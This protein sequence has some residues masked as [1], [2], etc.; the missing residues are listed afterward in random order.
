MTS[1]YYTNRLG[2]GTPRLSLAAIAAAACFTAGCGYIGG[3]LPPFANIPSPVAN[4]NAVQRGDKLIVQFPVPTLTTEGQ[5]L[6]PPVTPELRIGDHPPA[7]PA[8]TVKDGFARYEIPSTGWIGKDA[9]ITARVVGSN[10]KDSGWSAPITVSVVA[11]P[12]VPHDIRAESTAGGVRLTWQSSG[13]HFHILRRSGKETAYSLAAADVTQHEWLDSTAEFG[14]PYSYL[15]QTFVPLP[16]GKEAQSDLPEATSLTP[17]APPPGVP[18][19]LRA[20]PASVSIE[21]SWDSPQGATP[22][23][24]RLYR[25][26]AGGDFVKIADVSGVPTYSDHTVEAG[27]V[28]RY[29]V[30][31]VDA[32]G[33]EGPRCAPVEASLQ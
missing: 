2:P 30:S 27:K 15:V 12:D 5:P 8:V 1:A 11:P 25:A 22:S 14:T 18:T 6:E 19:G 4:L 20:L 13:A 29:A 24:Y 31:A 26:T 9:V 32:S 16:G 3:P 10:G 23:G 21:L 7:A 28:Y 17:E 33:R